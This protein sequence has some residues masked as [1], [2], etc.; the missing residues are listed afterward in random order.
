MKPG[1]NDPCHCGSGEKYKKC[2][3]AK[4]DASN[5]A[6]LAAESAKRREAA[7]AAEAE[8]A[9]KAKDGPKVPGAPE[10]QGVAPG[11]PN[12]KKAGT[13]PPLFRRRSSV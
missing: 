9:E 13:A 10:K 5:A 6:T 7:V 2:H 1:R 11:R 12:A 4:D 3:L 8:A